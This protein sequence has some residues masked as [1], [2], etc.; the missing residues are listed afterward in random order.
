MTQDEGRVVVAFAKFDVPDAHGDLIK[1]GAFGRQEVP[2]SPYNHSLWG[3]S[4]A[5]PLGRARIYETALEAHAEL[6]L[7]MDIQAARDTLSA[8]KFDGG[9]SQQYSFGFSVDDGDDE[10]GVT[11]EGASFLR[12]LRKLKV[13]ELSP[14]LLGAGTHTRTISAKADESAVA[15]L[16]AIHTELFG[17]LE[18]YTDFVL[19]D[20]MRAVAG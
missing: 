11:D 12:T 10:P 14:V 1:K 2:I 16:D 19:G 15:E 5:L 20:A 9:R 17:G 3:D 6:L 7:N 13:Y 8:I 18:A 4:G